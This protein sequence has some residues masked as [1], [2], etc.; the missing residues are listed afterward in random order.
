MSKF[1]YFPRFTSCSVAEEML[2]WLAERKNVV[3]ARAEDE[4]CLTIKGNQFRGK[5]L[6]A[7]LIDAENMVD[8]E[9]NETKDDIRKRREAVRAITGDNSE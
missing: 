6:V 9:P 2:D 7:L 1:G 3:L 4:W 8:D 5:D